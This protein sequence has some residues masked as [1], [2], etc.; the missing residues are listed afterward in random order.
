MRRVTLLHR[1]PPGDQAQRQLGQ[2]GQHRV[3]PAAQPAAEG[4]ISNPPPSARPWISARQ[5]RRGGGSARRAP[6]PG[7]AGC[8]PDGRWRGRPR[9]RT[10][11]DRLQ[12]DGPFPARTTS[13]T[14]SSS[15]ATASASNSA[16]V[17]AE[18]VVALR[19]VE[20]DPQCAVESLGLH[21]VGDVR[22]HRRAPLGQP[23]RTPVRTAASSRPAIR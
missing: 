12:K 13:V 6:V 1:A 8:A 9:C 4:A 7:C 3:R 19:T 20:P 18:C 17:G 21:R 16:R 15:S 22:R 5:R 2:P 11:A 23:A 14:V 10:P